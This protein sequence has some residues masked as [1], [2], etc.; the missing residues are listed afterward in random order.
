MPFNLRRKK[1]WI[2]RYVAPTRHNWKR[3]ELVESVVSW[4]L[5]Q[6]M[7]GVVCRHAFAQPGTVPID[8]GVRAQ[9]GMGGRLIGLQSV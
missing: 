1:G 9:A 5:R 3:D 2:P 4:T 6:W 8:K 7:N